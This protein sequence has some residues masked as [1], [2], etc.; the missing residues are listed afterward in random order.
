MSYSR[1]AHVVSG[2]SLQLLAQIKKFFFIVSK[3]YTCHFKI[4]FFIIMN[5]GNKQFLK[6]KLQLNQPKRNNVFR[7]HSVDKAGE[8][9]CYSN[10]STDILFMHTQKHVVYAHQQT[11]N[12]HLQIIDILLTCKYRHLTYMHKQTD[13]YLYITHTYIY[14][15]LNFVCAGQT[16]A[17]DI[18]KISSSIQVTIFIFNTR[19]KYFAA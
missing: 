6:S 14:T 1:N 18:F 11:S 9:K 15:P 7:Y 17:Q 2:I 8:I 4:R 5:D 10:M 13:I 3:T 19:T 12:S 16:W